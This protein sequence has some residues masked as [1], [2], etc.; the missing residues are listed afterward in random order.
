VLT[1]VGVAHARVWLYTDKRHVVVDD[2][3]ENHTW[4]ILIFKSK[5]LSLAQAVC[6]R[7][8]S[9]LMGTNILERIQGESTVQDWCLASR[10]CVR[11]HPTHTDSHLTGVVAV[12]A[13]RPISRS[14]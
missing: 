4:F 10:G 11:E 8:W 3:S 6:P 13:N 5:N 14:F 7:G 2:E 12:G 1:E 9:V